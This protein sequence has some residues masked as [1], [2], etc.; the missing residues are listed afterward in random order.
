MALDMV[1]GVLLVA[2]LTREQ[3]RKLKK[4]QIIVL[5]KEEDVSLEDG[6]RKPQIAARLIVELGLEELWTEQRERE[7]REREMADKNERQ[8]REFQEKERA[9]REKMVRLEVEETSA[10]GR[11]PELGFDL[12]R[13]HVFMPVFEESPVD[14]CFLNV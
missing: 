3:F 13:A 9:H 6:M 7:Q 1:D 2:D 5:T 4:E 8:L 11:K 12:N 14:G 10:G